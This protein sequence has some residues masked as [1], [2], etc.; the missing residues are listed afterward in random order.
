MV[1]TRSIGKKLLEIHVP[2]IGNPR[3]LM[4]HYARV[5]VLDGTPLVPFTPSEANPTKLAE[6]YGR[7]TGVRPIAIDDGDVRYVAHLYEYPDLGVAYL[8]T[9]GQAFEAKVVYPPKK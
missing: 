3:D 7:K 1:A 2:E 6:R 9:T 8:Q 4:G 5:V